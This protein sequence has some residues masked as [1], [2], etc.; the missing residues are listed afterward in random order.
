MKIS[1]IQFYSTSSV[2][3]ITYSILLL[4]SVE[5]KFRSSLVFHGSYSIR[6]CVHF[7][8]F[9][10]GSEGDEAPRKC[11]Q[12]K[13]KV[14]HQMAAASSKIG[15]RRVKHVFHFNGNSSSSADC[16][17]LSFGGVFIV[18]ICTAGFI[19]GVYDLR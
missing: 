2:Y 5:K 8:S 14:P 16:I 6:I 7:S 18:L 19:R 4:I 9:L 12:G 15:G 10:S 11:P 13:S 17:S 1:G 3:C